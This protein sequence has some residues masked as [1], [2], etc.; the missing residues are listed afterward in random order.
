M[1]GVELLNLETL[2]VFFLVSLYPTQISQTKTW[3]E[4]IT[5]RVLGTKAG[6]AWGPG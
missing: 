4:A 5:V 3:G 6:L 2:H 1:G